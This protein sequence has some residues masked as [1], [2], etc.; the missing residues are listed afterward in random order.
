MLDPFR[1]SLP[2]S[3]TGPNMGTGCRE[4]MMNLRLLAGSL[5]VGLDGTG[6]LY[7]LDAVTPSS[8]CDT[9]NVSE[10]CQTFPGGQNCPELR[11]IALM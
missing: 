9:K 7:Q 5:G 4:A 2:P 6:G 8:S 3:I 1:V 10:Y 11:T